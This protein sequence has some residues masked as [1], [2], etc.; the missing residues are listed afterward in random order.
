MAGK[1]RFVFGKEKSNLKL[2]PSKM[3]KIKIIIGTRKLLIFPKTLS[4]FFKIRLHR[5]KIR[6]KTKI[7]IGK[8]K[9]RLSFNEANIAA[10]NITQTEEL[11]IKNNLDDEIF[12]T[13]WLL[14]PNKNLKT[15]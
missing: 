3:T 8:N 7:L 15:K 2:S 4:P 10:E 13:T 14:R 11:K 9:S 5:K 6:I 1:G 12:S